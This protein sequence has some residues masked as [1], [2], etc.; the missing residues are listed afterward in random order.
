MAAKPATLPEKVVFSLFSSKKR[1]RKLR[2]R[3]TTPNERFWRTDVLRTHYF[4]FSSAGTD[5]HG[6]QEPIPGY[7]D[8]FFPLAKYFYLFAHLLFGNKSSS[9]KAFIFNGLFPDSH[10]LLPGLWT[11]ANGTLV[12][13]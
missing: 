7:R 2:P 12:T 4:S 6:Q 8:F 3:F 11:W 9:S 13:Y 1:E 5:R 10:L